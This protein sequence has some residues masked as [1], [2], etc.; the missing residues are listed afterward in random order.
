[1]SGILKREDM[2][3]EFL[4]ELDKVNTVNPVIGFG[5]N[6]VIKSTGRTNTSPKFTIKGKTI[7]NLLGRDGNCEDVSKWGTWNAVLTLDSSNKVFGSN[8]IKVTGNSAEG[9]NLFKEA[10]SIMDKTK[11][12]CLSSYIKNGN[13]AAGIQLSAEI[14]NGANPKGWKGAGVVTDSTK[15]T[16]CFIKLQPSELVNAT[17][18]LLHPF[19]FTEN[20]KYAYVDGAMLEEITAAQYADSSFVPSPYVDSY[21]CLTNPYFEIRHNNL[22]INGNT[23]DGSAGWVSYANGKSIVENGKFKFSNSAISDSEFEII[24]V[25][26]NT[27][28]VLSANLS[29][30]TG[31]AKIKVDN[32]DGSVTLFN[33]VGTFNSGN[34]TSIRIVRYSSTVGTAYF[35]SIMLVEGTVA[36]AFYKSSEIERVVLETKLADG[37]SVTYE[38]GKVDGSKNV[39]HPSPLFGKDYAWQFGSDL[40]GAKSIRIPSS[41]S[42]LRGVAFSEKVVKYDGSVLAHQD[43]FDANSKDVSCLD[44][45]NDMYL[46]VKDVDTG[47]AE[48]IN[49]NS[50]EIKAW[51][52]GWKSWGGPNASNRYFIWAS[53]V[54]GSLPLVVPQTTATS[55][56][57]ANSTTLV[58][59]DGSKF[60]A[61]ESVY[62]GTVGSAII[63]SISGNT[64]TLSTPCGAS[65][66]SG[67]Q[68]VRIDN[69]STD[70][71]ILSYCINN[72]APGYE[73]YQLHYKLTNP[74]TLT[75]ANCRVHG[76]IPQIEEGDN[77]LFIDS[78]IVI[79]EANS[80]WY[81]STDSLYYMNDL[82]GSMFRY[83]SDWVLNIFKNGIYNSSAWNIYQTTNPAYSNGYGK[84]N[85]LASTN[86]FDASAAYTVDYKILATQ[87]PQ[88]GSIACS[89]VYDIIS[90]LN[91][92]QEEVD[93][94]QVHD[95]V[96]DT[97]IDKSIY[98]EIYLMDGYPITWAITD[99]YPVGLLLF[100]PMSPK[101]VAKPNVTVKVGGIWCP[102]V[103]TLNDSYLTL[104]RIQ[105][106]GIVISVLNNNPALKSQVPTRGVYV[107]GLGTWK[108]TIDCREKV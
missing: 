100:V 29:N 82:G 84:A 35:D 47:F 71:R 19:G 83:K 43:V 8:G 36:P 41:V 30:G 57:A 54:D 68:V 108:I 25:R 92:V 40:T 59:A 7:V 21:A 39:K 49:P 42:A 15:F 24:N 91:Q 86:G 106:N 101:K 14:I 11:Y 37:D 98:E 56:Y 58:V 88:I 63:G 107:Q 28:Y 67:S 64:L 75:D 93:S 2:S 102:G 89:Y 77:Y 12:Y 90:V 61:G 33:G 20:G 3:P 73:G 95:T 65:S 80:P 45:L 4:A 55:A 22:V 96:L 103:G 18:I 99:G 66:P 87:A 9:S 10:I 51:M 31:T 85:M 44:A 1:M 32:L 17:S 16:R 6:N 60:I 34:N 38:N 74:E 81:N 78:G 46:A 13:T 50:N 94:R 27:D 79:G 76:D 97:L 53:L 104:V 26:P 23:E 70:T 105:E 69:G 72:I 5:M 62:I 48:G 52:N